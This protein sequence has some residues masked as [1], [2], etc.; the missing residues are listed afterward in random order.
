MTPRISVIIPFYGTNVSQLKECIASLQAQTIGWQPLEAIVIDNNP[1]PALVLEPGSVSAVLHEPKPGSYAARN[2]GVRKASAQIVAFLDADCVAAPDWAAKIVERLDNDS[3]A[4]IIAGYIQPT[5]RNPQRPNAVEVYD[6]SVHMR[7]KYYVEVRHFGATAN[8]AARK[9]VFDEVGCFND[10]M[11]SGGDREWCERAYERGYGVRYAEDIVVFHPARHTLAGA[12][13]KGRRLVGREVFYARQ[14]KL[15]ILRALYHEV[16]FAC[17][18]LVLV[19]R[20]RKDVGVV[21]AA[22]GLGVVVIVFL[23]RCD[24]VWK[25]RH[26]GGFVR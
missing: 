9:S 26:G 21:A 20:R 5:Y 24:Q 3:A 2:A 12:M 13:T 7:Q 1:Q 17:S 8:L 14:Q 16:W 10:S 6:S 18:R 19:W 22:R 23:A 11:L 25:T 4:T 15:A